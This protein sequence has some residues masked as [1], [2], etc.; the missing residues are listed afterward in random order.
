MTLEVR[1]H[2]YLNRNK[3]FSTE[4]LQGL[5]IYWNTTFYWYNTESQN[6][7]FN[8]YFTCVMSSEIYGVL[9]LC[10]GLHYNEIDW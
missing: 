9:P 3:L 6:V 10:L 8:D 4:R 7:C 2:I 1:G 5:L